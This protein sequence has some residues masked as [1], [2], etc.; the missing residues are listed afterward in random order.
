MKRQTFLASKACIVTS[1]QRAPPS[2]CR[3]SQKSC[4]TDSSVPLFDID[5]HPRHIRIRIGRG[6]ASFLVSVRTPG[7][8]G[9][10]GRDEGNKDGGPRERTVIRDI[11]RTTFMT[12]DGVA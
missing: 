1:E 12:T 11:C 7:P 8:A 3:W 9:R 4:K 10:H 2:P 6:I 5:E